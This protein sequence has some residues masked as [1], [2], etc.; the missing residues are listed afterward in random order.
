MFLSLFCL[1]QELKKI[2]LKIV[3]VLLLEIGNNILGLFVHLINIQEETWLTGEQHH[4]GQLGEK[5]QML[6]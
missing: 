5:K 4:H 2:I 1:S 6:R 3:N